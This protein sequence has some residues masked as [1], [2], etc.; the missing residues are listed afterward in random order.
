MQGKVLYKMMFRSR[1]EE[2]HKEFRFR[3]KDWDEFGTGVMV[4]DGTE[5]ERRKIDRARRGVY[6]AAFCIQ[7]GE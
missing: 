2:K 5:T 1:A 6:K 7:H 3:G 4:T